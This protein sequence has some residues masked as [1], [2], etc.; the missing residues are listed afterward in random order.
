MSNR[1]TL[2]TFLCLSTLLC[3]AGVVRVSAAELDLGTAYTPDELAKVRQWEQTYA[4]KSYDA[5]TIDQVADYML[6]SIASVYKDPAKWG[7]D[8]LTFKVVPYQQMKE[9]DSFIAATQ[10]NQGKFQFDGEKITNVAEVAGRPFPDPKNGS[11]VAWNFD[12][13]NMGDSFQYRRLS[14][15]IDPNMKTDRL[16]DQEFWIL[17]YVNRT[18]VDPTPALEKNKKG[19][20]RGYFNHMFKPAEFLNTRMYVLRYIDQQKE[21]DSYLYYSQY[22]RIRR[23]S[24]TQRTD[25]ID[26]TDL[27]YDDEFGWDGQITRNTY[28]LVGRK[29]LLCSRHQNLKDLQR[30]AGQGIYDGISFER[31]NTYVVEAVSKDPNY[32]YSKRVWYVDPESYYIACEEM[33]DKQGQLWKAFMMHQDYRETQTGAKR[34]FMPGMQF[35]DLQRIHSGIANGDHYYDPKI[36]SNV[37]AN[38][39][40]IANLQKT[41]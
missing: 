1:N 29:D 36:S 37:K 5:T 21:D 18:E 40:T 4:G 23:L 32:L 3:M 17:F 33:F 25:S 27:C 34:P 6:G 20:R 13:N 7:A 26:G 2:K 16:S 14:P 24:T 41:Y 10:A 22:R 38:M 19:V 11:E 28:K 30:V 9:T 35:V 8:T 39:F 15:N 31:C 12:M